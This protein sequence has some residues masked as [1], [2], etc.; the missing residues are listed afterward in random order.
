MKF[1]E[2]FADAH[3]AASSHAGDD[4]PADKARQDGGNASGAPNDD[5]QAYPPIAPEPTQR[6]ETGI[7]Y[8]FNCGCRVVLPTPPARATWHIRL[9]DR[10]SG[11][12]L[13]EH[14]GVSDALVN[15]TKRWFVNFYIEVWKE[16][17]E[18]AG[19]V[20]EELVFSHRFDP[21]G[22]DILIQFPVGTLGDT[23]GW[24]PY[25][26]RFAEK[27]GAHITCALSALIRPL[28]VDAYP[29]IR[30]LTHEEINA[31][32]LNTTF[33]ATYSLGLFF[34]DEAC[35]WQ[36]TDFRHVGLHRTA[37]HILGVDPTEEAARISIPD[38]GRP[39]DEPYVCIAAQ[40]SSQCK[41]WNNP[42][43]WGEVIAWLKEQGYRVVCID[44]K[45]VHGTGLVWNHIP[46]GA[47]DQ[48]GDRPLVERARWLKHADF[49]V[50]LSSGLSWLAWSTGTPVVMVSGFTHPTNEFETS[51][52]VNCWHVCNSCWNDPK[53]RFDHKDFLWCPRHKGTE[54]Q[55]ECTKSVTGKMVIGKILHIMQE[56]TH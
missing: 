4:R 29:H 47:E 17:P 12:I 37:A 36:P 33:Y 28:F 49:F 43:G 14:R 1:I 8:D 31:Q 6:T 27:H 46:Y 42:Y 44:Q 45:R 22:K 10:D 56:R 52:R 55:F 15:S 30:F 9:T 5:A 2:T 51:G 53:E 40:A 54:R 21:R 11:N 13:F 16:V 50:G 24:M 25:A 38:E 26:A 39:I 7:R 19:G 18:P 32:K 23:L 41:Y 48:T 20:I 35:D 3:A 34:D